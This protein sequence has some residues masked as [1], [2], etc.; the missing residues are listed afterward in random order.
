MITLIEDIPN[1]L[2]GLTSMFIKIENVS[3]D[4]LLDIVSVIKETCEIYNY[5]KKTYV[6]EVPL[7]NISILIDNLSVLD[8]LSIISHQENK[9]QNLS[10][11]DP[12]KFKTRP[13]DY[14]LDGI[15][16]GLNHDKWLLLD[17]MGLGKTLQAIYVAQSLYEMGKIEHCLI[18]CGVD[19]L[20]S[21]WKKEIEKHSNL[22]AMILGDR[23]NNRGNIT[24][25]S[26]AYRVEQLSHKI[27]EFFIIT[28]L[29]TI[30]ND[31]V[32][33]ALNSGINNIGLIITDEIHRCKDVTS[34][35]GKNLLKLNATYKMAMTGSL[36]VNNPLDS[37]LPLKW[38]GVEKSTL[39][40]FKQY[41]LIYNE[42]LRMY[43]DFKNMDVLKEELSTCSLRRLKDDILD[44][45]KKNIINEYVDMSDE[46]KKLYFSVVNG[47]KEEVD[48]INLH[49]NNLLG[50]IVRLRQATS[51]PQ[52]LTSNN[53][54]SSKV[55]RAKDLVDDLIQNSNDKVVIFS[56]FKET[57]YECYNYF[58]EYNPLIITGDTKEDISTL[59]DSFQND[60]E[61]KV[62]I[63]TYQKLGTGVTLTRARYMI[64][65]DCPWTNS[66]YTQATD[67]IY[68]IGTNKPVFIYN[69]ICSN[70]IDERVIELISDKKALSDYIV[71][72]K[73]ENES[74]LEN[75]QKYIQEL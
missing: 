58:K 42:Q 12:L 8:E 56:G 74:A 19:S 18:L 11:V 7:K 66:D 57:C 67:R 22:S 70:T 50:L 2:P 17:D 69:L 38:I 49:S 24:Y 55:L 61:H 59:I 32:V 51:C 3:K 71:D 44:L 31:D 15:N 72:D 28:T 20:R 9:N 1:K 53:V 75:L 33:V 62:I 10:L 68:R 73:I 36:I 43:K 60:N 63:A 4:V 6:W 14:Q 41:F 23:L 27:N 30:R 13:F 26:V 25:E 48:K 5:D 54:V 29:T 39:T 46:H 21:N 45:P 34:I 37:Y 52:L 16:Y 65:I 47:V 35:Q 64:F 40:N